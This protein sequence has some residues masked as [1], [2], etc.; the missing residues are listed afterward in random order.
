MVHLD[1]AATTFTVSCLEVE[2][3]SLAVNPWM[4]FEEVSNLLATQGF[5][6]L[7]HEVSTLKQALATLGTPPMRFADFAVE[8]G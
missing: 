4:V 7:A 6:A 5:I 1:R 8:A 3:T 2:P